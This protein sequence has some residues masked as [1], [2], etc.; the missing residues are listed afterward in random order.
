MKELPNKPSKLLTLALTD[1]GKARR[2]KKYILEMSLWHSPEYV[3][4]NCE[5]C[6]AGTVMAFS[7]GAD[8][9]RSYGCNSF[10][11]RNYLK[12]IA[13]NCFRS[14]SITRA[15]ISLS[16]TV[17][18]ADLQTLVATYHDTMKNPPK[19]YRRSVYYWRRFIKKLKEL[20]H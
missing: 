12:L 11:P 15:F 4:E 16:I 2:S 8:P 19:D 6:M 17:K 9:E 1:M 18:D 20:G 5:V 7:L 10:G 14:G 3:R 13:I